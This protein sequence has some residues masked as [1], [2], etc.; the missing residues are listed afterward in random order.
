MK[1]GRDDAH[2]EMILAK[3]YIEQG[4]GQKALPMSDRL[5]CELYAHL[6]ASRSSITGRRSVTS[7]R[8]SPMCGPL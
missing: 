5:S 4:E 6:E 2:G 3:I 7:L 8:S 1:I